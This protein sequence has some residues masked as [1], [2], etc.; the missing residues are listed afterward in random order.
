M[1]VLNLIGA[2]IAF[3]A[4][5]LFYHL[6]PQSPDDVDL[7]FDYK[8]TSKDADLIPSALPNGYNSS[9]GKKLLGKCHFVE[10]YMAS[11]FKFRLY[12]GKLNAEQF[13]WT[14]VDDLTMDISV[15]RGQPET[16]L[17]HMSGT[18][19]VEAWAGTTNQLVLL[20]LL[21]K[22]K[23]RLKDAYENTYPTIVF[24]H[25]LNPYGFHNNRR[26]NE[27]NVDLNRNF[28]TDDLFKM[29]LE[30]NP[31]YAGYQDFDKVFNPTTSV[32]SLQF[33]RDWY[34]QF[35]LV[36]SA[37]RYGFGNM[38]RALVAGNYFKSTGV[39]FG[40]YKRTKS[41][42]TLIDFVQGHECFT[43]AKDI[44][45]IDVH[46]GLGPEGVDTLVLDSPKH[47]D[48]IN[49]YFLTETF[50]GKITG[51]IKEVLG[52]GDKLEQMSGYELTVGMITKNFC[53]NFLALHIP[54]EKKL[55]ITQE[56][57]TIPTVKVGL[58]TIYENYA[59]FHGSND[60]K[61]VYSKRLLD[62]FYV[63]KPSWK[64]NIIRRG[65]TV[66]M[67]AVQYL[68]VVVD[69]QSASNSTSPLPAK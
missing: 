60:E 8:C 45:V 20:Q 57:G 36:Y 64:H 42:Q 14:V 68:K 44:V 13:N 12:S 61:R 48:S 5:L 40:G 69:M 55:C 67:E 41:V 54:I 15:V 29:V 50:G 26:V 25:S 52:D 4:V 23:E 21:A 58:N 1:S 49:K 28:L 22:E 47:K 3:C 17:L 56:F 7:S 9:V 16:L 62:S 30:R 53:E 32:S 38:K 65:V 24:V 39:G 2:L 11:R 34:A 63:N 35:L 27:D 31:N 46:T 51:G 37:F 6:K 59:T 43:K 19:G 18:H 66:F 10:N 33:I